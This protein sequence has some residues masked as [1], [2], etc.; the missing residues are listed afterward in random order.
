MTPLF[1][2]TKKGLVHTQFLRSNGPLMLSFLRA[3]FTI[4][5]CMAS[6]PDWSSTAFLHRLVP[7]SSCR[8]ISTMPPKETAAQKK[9]RLKAGRETLA[10]EKKRKHE[11]QRVAKALR[12]QQRHDTKAA[13]SDALEKFMSE[14]L[15]AAHLEKTR[16]ESSPDGGNESVDTSDPDGEEDDFEDEESLLEDML[17]SK[18]VKRKRKNESKTKN[19]GKQ[20][21]KTR[22]KISKKQRTQPSP[23]VRPVL[24]NCKQSLLLM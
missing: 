4:S 5:H 11:E 19:S 9:A 23:K 21:D 8:N 7:V 15:V 18:P 12:L 10:L 16:K 22:E 17:P 24:L 6:Y 20:T 2:W 13:R 1:H 3:T 14:E